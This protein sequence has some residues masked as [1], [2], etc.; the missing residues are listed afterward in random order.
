MKYHSESKV[1]NAQTWPKSAQVSRDDQENNE[2]P[3]GFWPLIVRFAFACELS[4][5][6]FPVTESRG[7][8][9]ASLLDSR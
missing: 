6:L 2:S 7:N 3:I 5:S 4:E 1:I 9:P 8:S